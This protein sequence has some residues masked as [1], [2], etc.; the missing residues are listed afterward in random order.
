MTRV[1]SLLSVRVTCP[2]LAQHGSRGVRLVISLTRAVVSWSG[3]RSVWFR[4]DVAVRGGEGG[5]HGRCLG[6]GEVLDRLPRAGWCP[7][8]ASGLVERDECD[9]V[10][11]GVGRE[12]V[13]GSEPQRDGLRRVVPLVA[14]PGQPAFQVVPVEV[15]EADGGA[16]DVLVIGQ[17]VKEA[18]QADPV[19]L[20]RFR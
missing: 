2:G 8:G 4:R 15:V 1:L 6:F 12:R 19:G 13:D 16:F 18:F 17:V 9:V 3:I 20:D 14:P 10:V 7:L 5:E 11:G